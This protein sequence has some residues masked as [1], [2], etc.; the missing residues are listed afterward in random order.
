MFLNR[1]VAL[2]KLLKNFS[3]NKK[4]KR[5]RGGKKERVGENGIGWDK[6]ENRRGRIITYSIDE[7]FYSNYPNLFHDYSRISEFSGNRKKLA[8]KRNFSKAARQSPALR[9]KRSL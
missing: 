1:S 8:R 2:K 6:L 4:K 3:N 7:Y 9:A 5:K